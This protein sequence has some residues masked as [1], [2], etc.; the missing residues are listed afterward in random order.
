MKNTMLLAI[1]LLGLVLSG[2]NTTTTSATA[3]KRPMKMGGSPKTP[4][5]SVAAT[6]RSSR[7]AGCYIDIFEDTNFNDNSL[8]VHGPAEYSNLQSLGGHDWGDQ[9]GSVRTGPNCWAIVYSDENFSDTSN[10]IG[11]NSVISDLGDLEDEIDSMK[12]LD[13]AP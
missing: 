8:R 2:C 9:I 7:S 5:A 4:T 11:P 1:S 12:L 3:H 10:V 13:H 6:S